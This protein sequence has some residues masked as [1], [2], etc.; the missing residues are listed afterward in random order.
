MSSLKEGPAK[1]RIS[2][3]E[4]AVVAALLLALIVRVGILKQVPW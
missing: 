1:R 4:W 2:L 3:D